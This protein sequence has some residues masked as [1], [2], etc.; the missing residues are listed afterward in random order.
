MALVT[1]SGMDDMRSRQTTLIHAVGTMLDV[2]ESMTIWALTGFASVRNQTVIALVDDV[3][4]SIW[5]L[6]DP[7]QLQNSLVCCRK[8]AV[9]ATVRRKRVKKMERNSTKKGSRK[10]RKRKLLR[11]RKK[12]RVHTTRRER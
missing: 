4:K 1:A 10:K 2:L 9:E 7:H 12:K 11:R 3:D 5:V 6:Q 8:D